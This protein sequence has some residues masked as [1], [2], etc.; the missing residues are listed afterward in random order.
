VL[1]RFYAPDLAADQSGVILPTDEATHLRRVLRLRVGDE[2]GV[3]DGR[4]REFRA[5]VA[6]TTGAVRLDLLG[7]VRPAPEPR[8][9]LT[10]AQG[11]LKTDGMD[12]VVRDATMLGVAA[13]VPLIT[14]R[15]VVPKRAAG[16]A[17]ARWTRVAV[18]SAKQCGRAV[19]PDVFEPRP[20][21]SWRA[22]D[23][24][25]IRIV[26]VEPAAAPG[27]ENG[28]G[29]REWSVPASAS[30]L[31]GPEGGW[32]PGEIATAIDAGYVPVTLGGRTLRADAIPI[33]ALS[34]LGFLW[35]DRQP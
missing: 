17:V 23:A 18:A 1:P 5:R 21:E 14:N 4:G 24:S 26:L 25:E 16:A 20:I 10:L 9:R 13:I 32:T 30:V 6:T 11:V 7:P 27:A 22:D 33:A 8:V 19:V 3:F 2:V 34:I 28:R 12:Q 31:A 29:L 35:G 15:T